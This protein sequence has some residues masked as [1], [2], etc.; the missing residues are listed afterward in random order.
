MKKEKLKWKK[1][2]KRT[3]FEKRGEKEEK[4]VEKTL[5]KTHKKTVSGRGIRVFNNQVDLLFS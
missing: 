4:K 5:W 2:S 1:T 3:V